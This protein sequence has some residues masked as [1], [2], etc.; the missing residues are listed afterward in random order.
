M[1]EKVLEVD[2]LV[3][4]YRGVE[5]VRDVSFSVAEGEVVAL[6]GPNGAGK[7]TTLLTV[8]GLVRP[9]GGSVRVLGRAAGK[10]PTSRLA[11]RGMVMVPDDRGLFGELSV[12]DTLRLAQRSRVRKNDDVVDLLPALRP[13]WRRRVALLSGGEQQMVALAAAL[14]RRPRLLMLDEMSLGLAPQIVT[15]LLGAVRSM[16]DRDGTG[17]LLVEQHARVALGASDRAIVL[18]HGEIALEG[19][20][21]DVGSRLEAGE[22]SYLGDAV[23]P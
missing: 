23:S 22:G 3:G 13:L 10:E 5:V 17:V 18:R 21:H 20:R 9:I 7:T 15:G 11:R 4:G 2:S 6:L 1:S 14:V 19:D 16:A 12:A 8:A